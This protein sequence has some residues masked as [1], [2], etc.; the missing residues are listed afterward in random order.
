MREG[1]WQE[2]TPEQ[3][4]IA[5]AAGFVMIDLQDVYRGQKVESIRLADWDH[6]PNARGHRVIAERL[7]AGLLA[8][9]EAIFESRPR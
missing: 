1:S 2:D 3:V 9:R 6:H 7:H 5:Q 8:N 4:Q